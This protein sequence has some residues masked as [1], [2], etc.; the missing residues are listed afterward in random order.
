MNKGLAVLGFLVVAGAV[1]GA[2]DDGLKAFQK[3]VGVSGADAWAGIP[4]HPAVVNPPVRAEGTKVLSL[5]GEWEFIMRRHGASGRSLQEIQHGIRWGGQRN[6]W[7][8]S[9]GTDVVHKV[10]VPGC[11]EANGIGARGHSVSH[12]CRDNSEHMLRNFYAGSCWYRKVV[13]IPADWAGSRLWLKVG[14][15]RSR[16]WFYVNGHA[17]ALF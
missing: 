8:A 3:K 9:S 4:R 7:F 13:K 10:T 2:W 14:G 15:V 5:A 17:V 6:K 1:S 16:G 11:W 12:L